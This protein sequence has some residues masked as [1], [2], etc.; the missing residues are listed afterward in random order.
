VVFA[1]E[2]PL[3]TK[4]SKLSELLYGGVTISHATIYKDRVDE[5]EVEEMKRELSFLRNQVDYYKGSCET[6]TKF[7]EE[8]KKHAQIK[9]YFLEK[10][11]ELQKETL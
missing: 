5:S 10:T 9:G 7:V 6:V 1:I 4:K 11:T 3:N 2:E 8:N